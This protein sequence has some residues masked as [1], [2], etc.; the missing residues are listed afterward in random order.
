GET[1]IVDRTDKHSQISSR[2]FI[3]RLSST[4]P[5][6]STHDEFLR[7]TSPTTM[8]YERM[9]RWGRIHLS[10]A[11]SRATERLSPVRSLAGSTIDTGESSIRNLTETRLPGWACEIRT[12]KCRR[13]LCL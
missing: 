5:I 7:N 10:H 3:L 2:M 9:F 13:K 1:S 6:E 12:Q 4:T 8:R 11:R